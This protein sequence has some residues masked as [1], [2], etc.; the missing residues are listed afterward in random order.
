METEPSTTEVPDAYFEPLEPLGIK[1]SL[2][3][4]IHVFRQR[5]KHLLGISAIPIFLWYITAIG[6][7]NVFAGISASH[8]ENLSF[9][10]GDD[11]YSYQVQSLH[12]TL[13]RLGLVAEFFL[14]SFLFLPANAANIR[15]VAGLYAGRDAESIQ[16]TLRAIKPNLPSL[17]LVCAIWCA[18]LMLPLIVVA[19]CMAPEGQTQEQQDGIAIYYDPWLSKLVFGLPYLVASSTFMMATCMS[20][21]I[22]TVKGGQAIASLKESSESFKKSWSHIGAVTVLWFLIKIALTKFVEAINWMYYLHEMRFWV[23]WEYPGIPLHPIRILWSTN[24]DLWEI[25]TSWISVP[26]VVF[27]AA[28]GSVFQAMFYLD[29]RIKQGD[30]T[31]DVLRS[32]LGLDEIET[33]YKTM[34]DEESDGTPVPWS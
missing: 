25:G 31:Q 7:R 34:D 5:W 27:L 24:S 1:A 18:V 2:E 22:I 17:G 23:V 19:L 29:T 6:I 15:T 8:L 20:Y 11:Y 16:Q 26:F 10:M 28:M 33:D 3:R 13:S 4:A 32:E 12:T 30:C 21:S 9:E 14:F